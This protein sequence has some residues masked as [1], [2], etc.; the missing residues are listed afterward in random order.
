ME[1]LQEIEVQEQGLANLLLQKLGMEAL[2]EIEVQE[3]GLGF[4]AAT[5][6]SGTEG[7]SHCRRSP[8]LAAH[9]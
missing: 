4:Q 1:A 9:R 6:A 2:Q 5:L 7:L 3:Q 8:I